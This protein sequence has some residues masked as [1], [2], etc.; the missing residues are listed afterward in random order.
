MLASTVQTQ[1]QPQFAQSERVSSSSSRTVIVGIKSQFNKVQLTKK[2]KKTLNEQKQ[3]DSMAVIF[4][5][6]LWAQDMKQ[7]N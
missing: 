2:K 5:N 4:M 1:D 3:H 7:P 6:N